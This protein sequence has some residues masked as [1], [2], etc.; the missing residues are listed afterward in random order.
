MSEQANRSSRGV[1]LVIVTI[2]TFLNPFTGS[3]INLAL[4]LIGEEFA[5][6]AIML[7]WIPAAYLLS[8]AIF[9]LP[10]G[11][12]GDIIGRAKVF[13][14]GTLVYTFASLLAFFSPS[15]SLLLACRFLQGIG[16]A[17]LYSTAIA[18]IADLY[19]PGER[20][21]A[22][23]INVMAV[24]GGM[25]LGPFIGGILTQLFGWRSIFFITVL[26]GCIVLLYVRR[27]PPILNENR[28]E[29][30]DYQG[31]VLSAIAL[32]LFFIGT[33]RI[34]N[35]DAFIC[36]L[37]SGL[38]FLIFYRVESGKSSPLFPITLISSNRTFS[39]SN[40]AAL[41]NYSATFAVTFL[42]SLYLQIVRGMSP[43]TA[44]SIL[45]IQ[46]FIQMVIAPVAGRL[47]DRTDTSRLAAIGLFTSS[48][49]LLGLAFL[50]MDTALSWIVLFLIFLGFGLGLF[51][52]PNTTV[53]M[54]SVE[55]S[56][57][58]IASS[59]LATMRSTGM[60][61]SM[62]IVMIVFSILLGSTSIN[63]EMSQGFLA[64]MQIIFLVFFVLT[65]LGALIS[66]DKKN[67]DRRM[68]A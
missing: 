3:S 55:K 42:L 36:I 30:F 61:L 17:M 54:G 18:I 20:G 46:P 35:T 45:L 7:S 39:F 43:A 16:G 62:G 57:Y 47:S 29:T 8:S 19:P 51:S 12:L 5:I 26:L 21:R 44:G 33:S 25:T 48:A 50:G 27:I 22:V 15:A 58:G 9:L 23:G 28:R 64:S 38:T 31:A 32:V 2:G 66:L 52:T 40:L 14:T 68:E 65:I 13:S 63:P 56:Q 6:D 11:M 4:P 37:L 60:M 67:P 1:I 59:F 10:A 24:Y 53:V 34:P 41:I 49:G